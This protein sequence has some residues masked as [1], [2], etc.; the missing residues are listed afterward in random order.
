MLREAERALSGRADSHIVVVV[1][2]SQVCKVL[3]EKLGVRCL[4]GLTATSTRRTA[5]AVAKHLGIAADEAKHAVL[6]TSAV[7]DNLVL[8]VSRVI[9]V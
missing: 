2:L 3:R 7:P 1:I 9:T 5:I 4:V 8:S 6:F